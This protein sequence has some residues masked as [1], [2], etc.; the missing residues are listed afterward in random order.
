MLHLSP[1]SHS[2]LF[3]FQPSRALRLSPV[4]VENDELL[5]AIEAAHEEQWEL[6]PTPDSTELNTFWSSVETDLHN[7]PEW[8][9][10]AEDD[11]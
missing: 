7:D 6:E 3:H 4:P 10:F 2:S 5:Q 8:T 9:T 11:E 1:R